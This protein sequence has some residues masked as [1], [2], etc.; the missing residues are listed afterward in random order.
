[1][2]HWREHSGPFVP[3]LDQPYPGIPRNRPKRTKSSTDIFSDDNRRPARSLLED[4]FKY[5]VEPFLKWAFTVGLYYYSVFED[6][7]YT[8]DW[9]PQRGWDEPW[10]S[11]RFRHYTKSDDYSDE[12][13][14]WD[15]LDRITP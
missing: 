2:A 7:M 12:L 6:M 13:W 10:T 5:V 11:A 1:M 9:G 8:W 4:V 15:D 3:Y 14:T